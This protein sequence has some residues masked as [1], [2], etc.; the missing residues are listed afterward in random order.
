M[1]G[2]HRANEERDKQNAQAIAEAVKRGDDP[3]ELAAWPGGHVGR[4]VRSDRGGENAR[5]TER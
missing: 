5:D 1:V 2:K 4:G 3:K